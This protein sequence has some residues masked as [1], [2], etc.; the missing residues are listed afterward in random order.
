MLK[1]SPI[2]RDGVCFQGN[3]R[4]AGKLEYQQPVI[5]N[6]WWLLLSEARTN[7]GGARHSPGDDPLDLLTRQHPSSVPLVPLSSIKDHL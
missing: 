5:W 3:Y 2:W 1:L 7:S 6:D 4:L